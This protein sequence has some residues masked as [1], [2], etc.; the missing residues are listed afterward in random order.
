MSKKLEIEKS[1][2][3]FRL[4]C[5]NCGRWHSFDFVTEETM[6]LDG[7]EHDDFQVY[8]RTGHSILN[9]Q[10]ICRKNSCDYGPVSVTLDHE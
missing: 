7:D 5:P 9:P 3:G 10:F 1:E 8:A 2:T 4:A 6:I